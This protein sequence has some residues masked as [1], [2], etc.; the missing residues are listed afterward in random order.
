MQVSLSSAVKC[1][2]QSADYTSAGGSYD[3]AT[4][5]ISLFYVHAN[6]LWDFVWAG[7]A[8]EQAL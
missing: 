6:S 5:W 3:V 7:H 1:V 4:A 8:D 2:F